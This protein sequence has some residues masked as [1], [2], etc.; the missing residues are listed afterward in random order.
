MNELLQ[1]YGFLAVML[2]IGVF[3]LLSRRNSGGGDIPQGNYVTQGIDAEYEAL[4]IGGEVQKAAIAGK[5]FTDMTDLEVAKYKLGAD[6]QIATIGGNTS[7]YLADVDSRTAIELGDISA[8]L[9]RYQADIAERINSS[10]VQ[11]AVTQKQLETNAAQYI[12]KK[13]ASASKVASWTGLIGNAIGGL[14][15]WL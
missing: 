2:V 10:Q 3:V 12:A 7:R 13:Q 6:I 11:G 5:A 15:S 9:Q 4:K 14:F 1:R 8:E